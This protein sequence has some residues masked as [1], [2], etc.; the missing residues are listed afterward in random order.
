MANSKFYRL[1][2]NKKKEKET[3]LSS[4][5]SKIF[6]WRCKYMRRKMNKEHSDKLVDDISISYH[7]IFKKK[8]IL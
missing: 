1:E 7:G 6:V 8:L 2:K 5:K 4:Y 3:R